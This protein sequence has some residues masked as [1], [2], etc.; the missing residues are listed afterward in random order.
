MLASWK[1]LNWG[2]PCLLNGWEMEVGWW[3]NRLQSPPFCMECISC[4]ALTVSRVSPLHCWRV[5][6]G[7]TVLALSHK[8]L[9]KY[10]AKCRIKVGTVWLSLPAFSLP[11]WGSLV[12][13]LQNKLCRMTA[14]AW[15]SAWE[16]AKMQAG[17]CFLFSLFKRNELL[18]KDDCVVT[19]ECDF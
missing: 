2:S 9:K 14:F 17:D 16:T 18:N 4:F 1:A 5:G 7:G 19:W 15:E 12:H 6:R 11:V 13:P 8:R 10:I 3:E